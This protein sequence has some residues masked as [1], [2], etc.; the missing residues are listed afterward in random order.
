MYTYI[1]TY[2]YIYL[3]IYI[4]T[5]TYIYIAK[6]KTK[7]NPVKGVDKNSAES[8]CKGI[9]SSPRAAAVSD[10]DLDVALTL[11]ASKV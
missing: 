2:I 11:R 6:T 3:Y 10:D 8:A 7:G 9:A 4:Y 5:C 1:C